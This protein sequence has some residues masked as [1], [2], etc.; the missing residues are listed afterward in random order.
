MSKHSDYFELVCKSVCCF[1][2]DGNLIA[3]EFNK[4]MQIVLRDG[5]VDD[6]E[7]QLLGA[8]IAKAEAGGLNASSQGLLDKVREEYAIAL[9]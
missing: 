7:R 3:D 4:L 5:I 9:E 6:R 2:D 8:I 1:G